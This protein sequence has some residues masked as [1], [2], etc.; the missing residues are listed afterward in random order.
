MQYQLKQEPAA[1][2]KRHKIMKTTFKLNY[3]LKKE[4]YSEADRRI[5]ESDFRRA[6]KDNAATL[7]IVDDSTLVYEYNS[8]VNLNTYFNNFED[9]T[10]STEN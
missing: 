8:E 7:K 3:S 1:T 6:S 10:Y 5:E 9:C 2:D 4:G